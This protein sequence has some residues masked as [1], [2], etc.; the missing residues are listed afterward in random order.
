M[1]MGEVENNYKHETCPDK[2]VSRE[3]VLCGKDRAQNQRQG[4]TRKGQA[5]VPRLAAPAK[6]ASHRP[7]FA[8][9]RFVAFVFFA[10]DASVP[11]E[12]DQLS[13]VEAGTAG[14]HFLLLPFKTPAG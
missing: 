7:D 5:D 14:A 9:P 4:H 6:G 11:V 1:C 8:L 3:N 2:L 13:I 12:F 10:F